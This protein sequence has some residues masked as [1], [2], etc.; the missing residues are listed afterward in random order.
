M[1][2]NN[3]KTEHNKS[4]FHDRQLP[5]A[6]GLHVFACN[7]VFFITSDGLLHTGVVRDQS[8]ESHLP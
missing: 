7:T 8:V 3:T 4:A 6:S 1:L 5:S 2:Y